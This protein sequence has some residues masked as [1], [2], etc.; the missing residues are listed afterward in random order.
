M[1]S[2]A[3][4]RETKYLAMKCAVVAGVACF[5]LS[6]YLTRDLG[7]LPSVAI[8]QMFVTIVATVTGGVGGLIIKQ[9]RSKRPWSPT[10]ITYAIL[11]ILI[12]APL[13]YYTYKECM[14]FS[15]ARKRICNSY[16]LVG[17]RN[18]KTEIDHYISV[19]GH[20]PKRVGE[21]T[22]ELDRKYLPDGVIVD[23]SIVP[24][25]AAEYVLHTHHEKGDMEY[26]ASPN[27]EKIFRRIIGT[28]K[29]ED[30]SN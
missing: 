4:T 19:S 5:L 8:G 26:L 7:D 28:Q 24:K 10:R 27:S 2:D 11:L 1:E 20:V 29:W 16:A 12:V 13:L 3:D 17:I 15:L 6:T 21:A 23:Y 18:I 14:S 25:K 30:A 9:V 22:K